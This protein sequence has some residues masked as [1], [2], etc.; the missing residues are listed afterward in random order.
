MSKENSRARPPAALVCLAFLLL[1]LIVNRRP[2]KVEGP[3]VFLS[4]DQP[5]VWVELGAGFPSPGVYQLSDTRAILDVIKLTGLTSVRKITG[6]ESCSDPLQGGE[7]LTIVC[8]D[9]K[10]TKIQCSWMPASHRASF[11]IPLHPDRMGLRDWQFLPGIGPAMAARIEMDRQNNGD[12]VSFS[13]LKRVRGI[14]EKRLM[15]WEDFF[16]YR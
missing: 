7:L 10:V 16:Y 13:A 3:P 14:G 9:K 4:A 6:S 5:A 12:F 1:V 8:D 15:A 2:F 11:G